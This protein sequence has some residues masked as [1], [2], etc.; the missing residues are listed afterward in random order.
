MLE[1]ALFAGYEGL[2][3]RDK[4]AKYEVGTRSKGL[5]KVKRFDDREYKVIDVVSSNDGWG[6][7]V[8]VTDQGK[9]FRVSAPGSMSNKTQI[10]N[11]KDSFIGLNVTIQY[12]NLTPDGIP[13]HPVA[14]RFREDI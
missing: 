3:L 5:I 1:T 14:L 8:C 2:I 4:N 6:I 11:E 9:I 10:L 13:F 12:A 7:L